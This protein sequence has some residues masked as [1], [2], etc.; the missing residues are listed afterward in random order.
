MGQDYVNTMEKQIVIQD[1]QW[2]AFE[3]DVSHIS[4]AIQHENTIRED[5][6]RAWMIPTDIYIDIPEV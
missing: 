6:I 1:A 4:E 5:L 2:K 3:M